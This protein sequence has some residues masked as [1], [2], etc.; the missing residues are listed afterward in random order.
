MKDLQDEDRNL[1]SVEYVPEQ[2]DLQAPGF[3]QFSDVFARF[4][5]PPDEFSVRHYA[6]SASNLV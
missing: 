3:E 2:L 5:L 1:D 6:M 4:Q